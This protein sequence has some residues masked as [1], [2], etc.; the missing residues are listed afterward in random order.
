MNTAIKERPI[1][2]SGPMVR[3]ILDGHKTQTRRVIKPQPVEGMVGGTMTDGNRGWF[4]WKYHECDV[5]TLPGILAAE[6]PY[7][8]PG[9]RLWVREPFCVYARLP[10]CDSA[11]LGDVDIV[12]GPLGGKGPLEEYWKC[13]YRADHIDPGDGWRSPLFMPR[14]ASRITLEIVEVRAERLQDI[15]EED[16][17]AEAIDCWSGDGV[18]DGIRFH[19]G[20]DYPRLSRFARL[21]DSINEKR[22][23]SWQSNPWVRVVTFRVLEAA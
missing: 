23:Y 19:M 17:I 7:G 22:G 12:E 13:A 20:L 6:C 10:Q 5:N 3:A 1:L 15:I 18:G 9:D 14:W 16:A 21:W 2:F 8:Q 4:T 11:P